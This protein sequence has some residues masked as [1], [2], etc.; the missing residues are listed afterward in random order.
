MVGPSGK[1]LS[2]IL[3]KD[4]PVEEKVP[5]LYRSH[6]AEDPQTLDPKSETPRWRRRE[7]SRT[8]ISPTCH[9]SPKAV[10]GF[11]LNINNN[12]LGSKGE[13]FHLAVIEQLRNSQTHMQC[14]LPFFIVKSAAKTN[15]R[16]LQPFSP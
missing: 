10:S 13:K 3:P 7:L 9:G 12:C 1:Q 5:S 14:S 8:E 16:N 2:S 11:F 15:C 6:L 4:I